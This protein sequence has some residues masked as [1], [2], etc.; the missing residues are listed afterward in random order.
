MFIIIGGAYQ[1]K[2]DYAAQNYPEAQVIRGLEEKTRELMKKNE[3]ATEWFSQHMGDFQ[4]K[5]IICPD[6]FCGIVPTDK[7]TRLWREEWG[8]VMALLVK[9]ASEV[10]R[11]FCG[12][13]L[14]LK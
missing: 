3:N 5:V 8:R 11:V 12:L 6:I 1:G 2:G 4:G 13:P 14:K 9:N 7:E 10:T